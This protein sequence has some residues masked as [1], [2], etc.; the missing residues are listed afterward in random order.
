MVYGLFVVLYGLYTFNQGI[1]RGV[2]LLE[3]GLADFGKGVIFPRRALI[4]SVQ[5]IK[6]YK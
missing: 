3:I 6:N 2:Q 1:P 4:K 5:S